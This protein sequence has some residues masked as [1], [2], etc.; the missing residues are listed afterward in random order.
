MP[1]REL[2]ILFVTAEATPFA[3]VGGLADVAGALPR[4]LRK[5]GHDARVMM[6]C[7][8][9]IEENPAPA[10]ANPASAQ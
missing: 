5:L 2:N 1:D 10:A 6:P 9:M 8:R 3:K 7:Y 4:E